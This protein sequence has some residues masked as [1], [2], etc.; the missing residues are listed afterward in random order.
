MFFQM[1]V[2][3]E[4]KPASQVQCHVQLPQ[5]DRGPKLDDI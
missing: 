5:Q 2:T 4:K 1:E 3:P